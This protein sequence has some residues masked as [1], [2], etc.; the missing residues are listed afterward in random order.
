MEDSTR[1]LTGVSSVA[2]MLR[3]VRPNHPLHRE[4]LVHEVAVRRDWH[5]L[6]VLEQRRSTVPRQAGRMADY[7]IA[8]ERR[9]GDE[10]RI[11][12]AQSVE[13]RQ[14]LAADLLEGLLRVVDEVHLVHTDH[15]VGN[16]QQ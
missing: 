4:S 8:V 7:V 14:E 11:E 10:Q 12:H 6:E 1:D 3:A 13:K 16:A 9:N 5:V 15:E 2:L